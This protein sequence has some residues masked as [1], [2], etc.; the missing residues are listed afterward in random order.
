M[1]NQIELTR[2]DIEDCVD[3]REILEKEYTKLIKD[4]RT[5]ESTIKKD[6]QACEDTI[7]SY[8]EQ[9]KECE[10]KLTNITE[11][12]E[13]ITKG[14]K[15][16]S[17]LSSAEKERLKKY[18]GDLPESKL[19][20]C[21]DRNYKN[22]VY[23]E[24]RYDA[25]KASHTKTQINKLKNVYSEVKQ[26]CD[27]IAKKIEETKQECE[28][29]L[30]DLQEQLDEINGR[31]RTI[32]NI[33]NKL[34]CC[35]K[36][37]L[38]ELDDLISVV[39]E[40]RQSL[41]AKA[42]ECYDKH[43]REREEKYQQYLS[44]QAQQVLNYIDELEVCLTL[45]VDNTLG[46]QT[47][48]NK[49]YTTLNGYTTKVWEFNPNKDYTGVFIT[50]DQTKVNAVEQSL[51]VKMKER[52]G[53]ES[54]TENTFKPTWQHVELPL[55]NTDLQQIKTQYPNRPLFLGVAIKNFECDVCV[56][57]DNIHINVE[58]DE[59]ERKFS[60]ERCP[61]FDLKC[62]I[63]DRRSWVFSDGGVT[64]VI[65][66]PGV[67][68]CN[69]PALSG[70]FNTI[71]TY[72]QPQQ[73]RWLDLEYREADY[74]V[75]HEH[76]VVNSK[77]TSFRIDAAKSIECDVYNLWQQI[78]CDCLEGCPSG[79]TRVNGVCTTTDIVDPNDIPNDANIFVFYD[80]TS[81]DEPTAIEASASMNAWFNNFTAST[82]SYYGNMYELVVGGG[83]TGFR[84]GENYVAWA[85]YPWLGELTGYTGTTEFTYQT[86]WCHSSDSV[87]GVSVC[88]P[89][90]VEL[91]NSTTKSYDTINKLP[92]GASAL[93]TDENAG[94]ATFSGQNSSVIVIN[95]VDE[96]NGNVGL[97]H[98][99][100]NSVGTTSVSWQLSGVSANAGDYE[101]EGVPAINALE[102]SITGIAGYQPTIRYTKDYELFLSVY[103]NYD[104]FRA[105]VY[106]VPVGQDDNDCHFIGHVL[107]AIEGEQITSENY[108]DEISPLCSAYTYTTLTA[109]TNYYGLLSGNTVYQSLTGTTGPGLKN[110][111]WTAGYNIT[112]FSETA[113][114]ESIGVYFEQSCP[115]GYTYNSETQNCEAIIT[116]GETAPKS[117]CLITGYTS[118]CQS[119]TYTSGSS[120]PNEACITCPDG[121]VLESDNVT[122][123]KIEEAEVET[124]TTVYNVGI[125]DSLVGTYGQKGGRF[126]GAINNNNLPLT[127]GSGNKF[128]DITQTEVVPLIEIKA[129]PWRE[130]LNTVGVWT[131]PNVHVSG[132]N[133][134]PTNQWIGFSLE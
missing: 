21:L 16:V 100:A 93:T 52:Y 51:F 97:Y 46:T 55:S 129:A 7:N 62:V 78:D 106:P 114:Q 105:Y 122:C 3:R 115:S 32:T 26:Q 66:L 20:G 83:E 90:R 76:L 128:R 44:D 132:S 9:L 134:L 84:N 69:F 59:I 113:V 126:Y 31:I 8:E 119:K 116:S 109:S 15:N 43:N 58:T 117:D 108:P 5:L 102:E 103:N 131:D 61:S 24:E 38:E 130:R 133:R 19:Q 63:D 2:I 53:E 86:A 11:K 23:Q 125:G 127:L 13:S 50:G 27:T 68:D 121:Y 65:D 29:D 95:V 94:Y 104:Y 48:L 28:E 80:G 17:Q 81:L 57:V 118:F 49:R 124:F 96:S 77:E 111:G 25:E 1:I 67:E 120:A 18:C 60:F 12:I 33:I 64:K 35:N 10:E 14:T 82:P 39:G 110:F 37:V 72:N 45:E 107:G 34:S 36:E 22:I 88:Q 79:Y 112:G 87:G 123:T 30:K 47:D 40:G 54:V 41:V 75:N 101:G 99:G 98:L 85:T 70:N 42:Q 4:K 74:S 89:R 71:I 91:N 92:P 73:R 56:L 6:E